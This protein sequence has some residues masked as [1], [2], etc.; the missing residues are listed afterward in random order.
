MSQ[1]DPDPVVAPP[2]AAAPAAGE[3]KGGRGRRITVTV[4]VV[5]ACVL[6]P[7]AGASIWLK[8]QVTDTN[9]YVRTIKPLASNTAI[10]QAVA[11]NVTNALFTRVDVQQVAKEYLP[12]RAQPLAAPLSAAIRNYTQQATLRFLQ[13]DA[14]QHV[15]LQIN[16][17]AHKRLVKILT[18][19]GT[20]VQNNGKVVLDLGP[21]VDNVKARLDA[22]GVTVF[23]KIPATAAGSSITLIESNNLKKAQ[24][25][26]KLLKAVALFLPL[27][28]LALLAGAIAL[29]KRRRRTVLQASL[30][31]AFSMAVLGILLTVGRSIYL[32]YVAGPNIPK[33]AATAFYETLVHYLRVGLR[34]IA[35][36]ALLIAAGAFLSGPSR[37]AVG[38]RGRFRHGVDWVQGETGVGATPAARWVAANKRVLRITSILVCVAIFMLWNTPTV[39]VLIALVIVALVA[40]LVIELLSRAP[41]G[42]TG[43]VPTPT[44]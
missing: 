6:A 4:L 8:N 9:R 44:Q 16:T 7:I 30:G 32:D 41:A 37:L 36:I 14:F 26:V 31:I 25:G 39:G 38:I 19:Q 11:A 12:P 15:W 33:D 29:S 23:D 35:G 1:A 2:A 22:R 20:F 5:L 34:A 21:I 27:L 28:V 3:E 43:E 40:L 13:S 18:G 10:Q 42:P 17:R 24:Q